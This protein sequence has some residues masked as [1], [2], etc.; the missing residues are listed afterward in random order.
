MEDSMSNLVAFTDSNFATEVE[1]SDVPVLVDF[2]AEWCG[3]CRMIGPIVD[4]LANEYDGKVK[5]GKVNVDENQDISIKYG[6]R[7]IP[8]LLFFKDGK[9]VD[10]IVGAVP[11]GNIEQKLQNMI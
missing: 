5:I 8:A 11:K 1:G 4:E 7:S 3:P 6:I 2:W 10:Q 9:V